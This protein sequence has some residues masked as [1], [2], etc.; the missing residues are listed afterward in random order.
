[1]LLAF[2]WGALFAGPVLNRIASGLRLIPR[3][4]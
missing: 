1:M 2:V 3:R 4:T